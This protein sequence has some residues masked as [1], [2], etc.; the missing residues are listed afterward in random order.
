MAV[1]SS[2]RRAAGAINP[3]AVEATRPSTQSPHKIMVD[4][5]LLCTVIADGLATRRPVRLGSPRVDSLA[6]ILQTSNRIWTRD[7]M[8]WTEATVMRFVKRRDP[9]A[10]PA[11]KP[12]GVIVFQS[13]TRNWRERVKALK[14]A[15]EA[16]QVKEDG[17][18]AKSDRP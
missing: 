16:E 1:R 14:A 2:E 5:E 10:R 8:P 7:I 15:Q 17:A 6:L 3:Q 13:T 4:N 9:A 18:L 11:A 12:E